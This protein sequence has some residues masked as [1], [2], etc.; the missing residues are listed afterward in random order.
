MLKAAESAAEL[1]AILADPRITACGIGPAAGVGQQTRDKTL[2]VLAAG[3]ASVLDA[4]ALTSFAG[5]SD[6]L[7]SAIKRRTPPVILT[8][9]EGEFSRLFKQNARYQTQNVNARWP[10]PAALARWSC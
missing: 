5:Q 10:L 3:C 7:F 8:P 6:T 2:A 1:A 4:D 9:H